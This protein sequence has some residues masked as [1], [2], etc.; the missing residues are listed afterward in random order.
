MSQFY[1]NEVTI[2][3]NLVRDPELRV[4]KAGSGEVSVVS[5]TVAVNRRFKKADGEF[6]EET[7]FVNVELWSTAATTFSKNCGKGDL[8]YINGTLK[9]DRWEDAQG[10]K[11]SRYK[12]RAN[13]FRLIQK[14]NTAVSA[15]VNTESDEFDNNEDGIPF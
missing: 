3:G 9:E 5:A 8:V 15:S 12:V 2:A 7:T 1:L 14:K 4:V 10:N 6:G 13:N 11:R